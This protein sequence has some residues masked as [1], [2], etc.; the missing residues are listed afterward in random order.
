MAHPTTAPSAPA[1]A[2]S[3]PRAPRPEDLPLHEDVRWLASA[4]GSVIRRLEGDDAFTVV[5][6]LR[7]ACRARRHGGPGAPDLDALLRR[8]EALPLDSSA[9]AARAFT[10]FFL[11]INTA[12]HVHRVRRRRDYL[13]KATAGGDKL[14]EPQPASFRWVMRRLRAK[15]RTPADVADVLKRLDVRPVL[16]A[17][18]TEATR[19]TIL[20]LQAR[21]ADEL[22]A[23]DSAPPSERLAIEEALRADVELLWLTSEVRRDRPSVMDEV[24]T[25]L[26]YLETRLLDAGART[27]ESLARA[28]EEEYGVARP[29]LLTPLHDGS[30]VAGDRDGNPF[31]TPET[32]MA[33]TRRASHAMLGR[34]HAAVGDLI[35]KL[36]L[37]S[38]HA[39][40]PESL[41]ASLQ[42][43]RA[44]LPDVWEA[45]HKRDNDE[46]VRLK[47]AFM[48]GR[49]DATRRQVALR[50]AGRTESVRAAYPDASAFERDLLLVRECLDAAHADNARRTVLDPLLSR[51]RAHG[52]HGSRL[53]VGE[54]ARVHAEALADIAKYVGLPE[55]DGDALRRELLSRR[56]IVGAFMPLGEETRKTLDVFHTVRAIQAESGEAAA[57]TYVIS[58]T[59]SV[60]DM[61]RVLLL[62][63]EAGLVDLA[64]DT[65]TSKLDIVPLFETLAD[66]EGAPAIVRSLLSDPV[67]RRQLTARGN[68]QELMIGYSDSAKDAGMLPAAWALYRAQEEFGRIFT[69]AGV[70]LTL[71]HGRG[72]TVGRGGGSPVYRALAAL[73]PGTVRGR[74]KITEQGE[75]ISQK[76]GLVPIAERSL[77]VLISGTLLHEF[78]DWREAIEPGEE[79]RFR[80][81]M[82]RL[83]AI[84]LPVYRRLVHEDDALFR[85]FLTASPVK[86][87]AHVHFGSRPVYREQGKESMDGIRAIPW[88]FGWTQ[89]RLMLPAWLGVGTA[90]SEVAADPRGLTMLRRMARLWPFFDDLIGNVEMVCAKADLEIARAYARELDPE[91]VDLLKALEE[92]FNRTVGAVLRIRESDELLSGN[93]VLQAAI[94]LR[95]PYVD[96]LSL[97]QIALLRRKRAG[98]DAQNSPELELLNEALG[99]TLNG[100][101]QGLRNTG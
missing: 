99:T 55:L 50:D 25:V 67:W 93:Q 51:L 31:V 32:T 9:V 77:E 58:M 59:R 60:D 13:T 21:V 75:V 96:P 35:R 64:G 92:E 62:A 56:T 11:L 66:L 65:P 20:D 34:Y 15:G 46:P 69:D 82:D 86:E 89:N 79:A 19:R 6:D 72:G 44:D 90:L 94:A 33:S 100:V 37:S 45:N 24:S 14:D 18:P 68:R 71:F 54:H 22:L 8:V 101:A 91:Q 73:P 87:L 4:L 49:I 48:Q 43:D 47:L 76:Y 63:R 81:T 53:D 74:I 28:F 57:S 70:E 29:P 23:R 26:W 41:R 17:H 85:F 38:R 95:N 5:E 16:T 61:L 42:A 39:P 1:P 3:T 88:S 98:S 27:R 40:V 12:E 52:F 83:S 97:L 7:Q 2:R 36:S 78:E 80:E 84:A 10:L 30:W